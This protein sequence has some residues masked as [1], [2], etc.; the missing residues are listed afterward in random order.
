MFHGRRVPEVTA[1]DD[2]S[3]TS[4]ACAAL[5]ATVWIDA[6]SSVTAVVELSILSVWSLSPL[7]IWRDAALISALDA[8]TWNAADCTPVAS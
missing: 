6:D 8:P 7:S 2:C 1:V 3:A 5:P 4:V